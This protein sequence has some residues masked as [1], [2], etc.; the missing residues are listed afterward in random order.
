MQDAINEFQWFSDSGATPYQ[1]ALTMAQQAIANDPDNTGSAT[2]PLYFVILLTDGYPTDGTDL[3]DAGSIVTNLKAASP[4]HVSL[5]TV[6]Y[7]PQGIPSALAA[8]SL[9]QT[10]ASDGSGQFANVNDPSTGLNISNII[11]PPVVC[12]Q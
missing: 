6:F 9:L 7:G 3:S 4:G 5:S 1:A 11:Q 12:P 2:G 10:M 8:M